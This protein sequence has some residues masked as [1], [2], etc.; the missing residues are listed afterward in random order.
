MAENWFTSLMAD[1]G[2]VAE[3]VLATANAYDVLTS[4]APVATTTGAVTKTTYMPEQSSAPVTPLPTG[5]PSLV[6]LAVA[7]VLLFVLLR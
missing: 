6:V 4:K 3:N 7:A 1:V 5:S 2:D